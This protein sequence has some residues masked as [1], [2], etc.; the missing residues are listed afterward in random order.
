MTG[1]DQSIM[2]DSASRTR[3]PSWG[4]WEN[5]I[6]AEASETKPRSQISWHDVFLAEQQVTLDA[7]QNALN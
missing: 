4:P 2:A 5:I 7:D 6:F 3:P 1:H